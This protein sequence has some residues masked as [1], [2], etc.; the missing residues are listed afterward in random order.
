MQ[1]DQ[2]LKELLATRL[3]NKEDAPGG[4][5]QE[6]LGELMKLRGVV[7]RLEKWQNSCEMG[8]LTWLTIGFSPQLHMISV[9][10]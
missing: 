5:V 8:W 1:R 3:T 7:R 2:R 10:P 9:T 4:T 6:L